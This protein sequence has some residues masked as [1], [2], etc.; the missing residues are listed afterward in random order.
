MYLAGLAV[1]PNLITKEQLQSWVKEAYWYML[2]E[3]TVAWV[4]AESPYALELAREWMQ[5]DEE[6]IV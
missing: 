1:D 4:A 5:S 2:S 6:I 3:Y